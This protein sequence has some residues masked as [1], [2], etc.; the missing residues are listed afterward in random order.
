MPIRARGAPRIRLPGDPYELFAPDSTFGGDDQS[1]VLNPAV[2]AP[3]DPTCGTSAHPCGFDATKVVNSGIQFP[4][5]PQPSFFVAV[6]APVGSYSFLC[7]LHPGMEVK[8]NVADAATTIPTPQQ[9]SNS[10][11]Q[12]LKKTIKIDGSAADEMAQT[13][14]KATHPPARSSR[15]TRAAS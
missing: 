14:T 2:G 13:V 5:S 6:T 8:L 9:V 1:L 10:A 15:S 4:N 11:A 3:S 7:L 12:Q